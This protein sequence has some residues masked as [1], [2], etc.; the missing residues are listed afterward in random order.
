MQAG[1]RESTERAASRVDVVARHL[2]A[3]SCPAGGGPEPTPA[4][5]GRSARHPPAVLTHPSSLAPAF[6]PM[7]RLIRRRGRAAAVLGQRG[8]RGRVRL[9]VAATQ[10]GAACVTPRFADIV[11]GAG[12]AGCVVAARLSEDGASSVLLIESGVEGDAMVRRAALPDSRLRR[13][14]RVGPLV[15]A[16]ELPVRL[17]GPAAGRQGLGLPHRATAPH[18]RSHLVLAAGQA[19]RRL[20]RPQRH[21]LRAR[22]RRLL[23][24]VGLPG[25]H[26]LGRRLRPPLLCPVRAL[27][28]ARRV[29]QA[30]RRRGAAGVRQPRPRLRPPHHPLRRRR[31]RGRHSPHRRLQRALPVRR[32][33]GHGARPVHRRG[34]VRSNTR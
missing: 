14:H 16:C 19:P 17:R 2:A 30:R 13:Q 25:L 3:G 4:G 22:V 28:R 33:R 31:R 9:C 18:A 32:A 21:A 27:H 34:H 10:R 26:R 11:V 5:P 1:Q 29:A 15:A 8:H 6:P 23:R 7:H 20:L 24:P 12:S